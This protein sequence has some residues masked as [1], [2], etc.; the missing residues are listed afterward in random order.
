MTEI[1]YYAKFNSTPKRITV[2]TAIEY[3]ESS[4]LQSLT[5]DV[6]NADAD[7]LATTKRRLPTVAWSGTFGHPRNNQSLQEHSGLIVLDFDH[8]TDA[9]AAADIIANDPHSYITFLSASGTGVKVVSKIAPKPISAATHRRAWAAISEYYAKLLGVAADKSGKDVARLCYLCYDPNVYVK[10]DAHPFLW[11]ANAEMSRITSALEY[12]DADDYSD[13]IVIGQA[14]HSTY[15]NNNAGL[16]IWD[17]WSYKSPKYIVGF[18]EQKW[19]TFAETNKGRNVTVASIFWKARENGYILPAPDEGDQE[20]LLPT[21]DTLL[22][23]LPQIGVEMRY[24]VRSSRFEVRK[25]DAEWS[26][27]VSLNVPLL[28][29]WLPLTDIIA[30]D[31][32]S[33]ISNN[34]LT[35]SR[36]LM[37]TKQAWW[38]ATDRVAALHLVDPFK[39]W[40]EALPKWDQEARL[41]KLW[42]FIGG[43][44]DAFHSEIA[45]RILLGAIRRTYEPGSPHDWM[46]IVVGPQGTGKSLLLHTLLPGGQGWIS[47]S[48]SFDLPVKEQLENIGSAVLVEYPEIAGISRG[49]MSKIK[50]H[51]SRV[52]DT[53]RFAYAHL[54]ETRPRRWVA[55]GTANEDGVGVLPPDTTGSRRFV[56]VEIKGAPNIAEM[57][58]TL[59]H[60]REQI[61]AEA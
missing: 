4:V 47:D 14:L 16:E 60:T 3:I 23:L 45:E 39:L 44:A 51:L 32:R 40:L 46:P 2:E 11:G 10:P 17:A 38:D 52:E 5:E 25:D 13:W 1:S 37:Y 35:R 15:P 26:K 53:V 48:P 55:I 49:E 56:T 50:A 41:G 36:P 7:V 8:L 29:D 57:L 18:C 43:R 30:A 27:V 61:W 24:N 59:E 20:D 28:D 6:H 31:L 22:K 33:L 58:D 21:G 12:I 19:D 42:T 34:F 54:P 9:Q